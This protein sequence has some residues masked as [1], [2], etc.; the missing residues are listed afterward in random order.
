MEQ[1]HARQPG[2]AQGEQGAA[3][4]P[5]LHLTRA[6]ARHAAVEGGRFLLLGGAAL[7]R[8]PAGADRDAAGDGGALHPLHEAKPRA[9]ADA[10]EQPS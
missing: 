9:G 10:E 3:G 5:L 1:R 2:L 6:A 4:A 7:L 8:R